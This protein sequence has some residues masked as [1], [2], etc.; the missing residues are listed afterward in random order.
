MEF[1]PIRVR[2]HFLHT[3]MKLELEKSREQEQASPTNG[4]HGNEAVGSNP[5]VQSQHRLDYALPDAVPQGAGVHLQ[6]AG[7]MD[8]PLEDEE[9][10]DEEEEDDDDDDEEVEVLDVGEVTEDEVEEPSIASATSAT[11]ETSVNPE[12]DPD[13][14]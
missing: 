9:E 13:D 12:P 6:T 4:Y 1:N 5:L 14:P 3:I 10:D 2:T 7:E 11:S 8:E